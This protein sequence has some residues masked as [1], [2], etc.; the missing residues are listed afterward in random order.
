MANWWESEPLATAE[1][2]P[3][4]P[5]K[6]AADN[7]GLY[8]Y[9][10]SIDLGLMKAAAAILGLPNTMSEGLTGLR[11]LY[12]GELEKEFGPPPKPQEPDT[13]SRFRSSD[14]FLK[15]INERFF[16][17]EEPYKPEG[18]GQEA[19]AKAAE[20]VGGAFVP[21]G[22]VRKAASWLLPAAGSE[23][24]GQLTKGT[25]YEPYARFLGALGPSLGVSAVAPRPVTPNAVIERQLPGGITGAQV[26]AAEALIRDAAARGVRLTWPEALSQVAQQPVLTGMQRHLEAAPQSA[27]RMEEFFARR[28]QEVTAAEQGA[29]GQAFPGPPPLQPSGI[30]R[31]VEQ[32]TGEILDDA[33]QTI[34][35]LAEPYYSNAQY[36]LVAPADFARLQ[37]VPGWQ[38]ARDAIRNTPQLNRYVEHLPDNSV[39]FLNE[40]KKYMGTAA[41]NATSPFRTQGRNV[42]EAA[43]WSADEAAVRQAAQRASDRASPTQPHGLY[44]EAL[45]R[46]GFFRERF[47]DPLLQ[48]PLGA[49]AKRD[50]TTQQAI[51][52]LFPTKPLPHSAQEVGD[53]VAA[54]AQRSPR[55][56]ND[57]VRAHVESVFDRTARDLQT[58]PNQAGGAKFR[59]ALVGSEQQHRNLQAA[60]E[61][62]PNGAERWRGFNR[63]LDIMEATGT[64]QNI[65]SRTAYNTE[66][67][68]EFGAGGAA[69][70]AAHAAFS[71]AMLGRR[72]A[73]KYD[74]WRLG[75]NL[76]E[77]SAILTDPRSANLLRQLAS[78]PR[79]GQREFAL[80]RAL[81]LYGD[82]LGR[83]PS[84]KV[85]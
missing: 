37:R 15:Q 65:G 53:A 83:K 34:N 24:A 76:N 66:A 85:E 13:P 19:T 48:G 69:E 32:A 27:G 38:E 84:E 57:L 42:Q 63:F 52:A 55:A 77:L 31:R 43:G 5:Q 11:Q 23:I 36:E 47:L 28:P 46:E 20:F 62:L 75:R 26:T 41:D 21:G 22:P 10:R 64:R 14:A 8:G 54:L 61:A 67:L 7:S 17:G 81:V 82:H 45:Q 73:E 50:L 1:T 74:Y 49:L 9:Y 12:R 51:E 78:A 70:V 44:T 25:E 60:I 2:P 39:G 56:A 3:A 16:P 72:A 58:G 4:Q 29:V 40:V 35:R 71:P 30:G 6:P 33:R 79:G 80:A 18:L 68:R 59:A